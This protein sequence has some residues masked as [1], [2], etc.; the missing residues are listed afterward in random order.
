MKRPKPV[1]NGDADCEMTIN[2]ESAGTVN[3]YNCPPVIE[4]GSGPSPEPQGE[5]PPPPRAEGACIP[6]APGAKHKSG[7][8]R[9]LQPLIANSSAPSVLAATILQQSRRFLQARDPGNDLEAS[10][11][12]VLASLPPQLQDTLS[13]AVE[14]LDGLTKNERDS[15]FSSAI[16]SVDEALSTT[17]IA[18]NVVAELEEWA[19]DAA[20]GEDGCTTE[21]PGL[22]RPVFSV[23]NG[24]AFLGFLPSICRVNGLRTIY[25]NPS[26]GPGDYEPEEFEQ[27]CTP[28]VVD[29]E[30]EVN[31]EVQ[32]ED[33]PGHLLGGE[34]GGCLRVPDVRNGETVVLEGINFFNIDATVGLRAKAPGTATAEVDAFVCGDQETPATEEKNGVEVPIND[35]RVQDR[36]TFQVPDELPP[37]IYEARVVVPNDTG[38]ENTDPIFSSPEVFIRVVPPVTAEFQIATE[39]LRAEKETSPAWFGSDEVGIRILSVPILANN[40]LGS[41]NRLD[42][43]FGD[44]DS[45]E[46]R[47]MASVLI[48]ESGLSGVSI[49]IIGFE[50]DS[51]SAFE[52]QIDSFTDAF[53][54]ILKQVWDAIKEE[55]GGAVA[56]IVKKFG[57]K[58]IIAIV[59]AAIIAVA[60]IALVALWAP[61]D[62]IIEDHIGLSVLELATLTNANFPAP[63]EEEFTSTGGIDVKVVPVSKGVQYRERREYRSD[64]EDSDYRIT[65]RYNRLS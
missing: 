51:E 59:I 45:G 34:G 40:T 57:V 9:K 8:S 54:D 31:C 46:V 20:L 50:I 19:A 21:A 28:E 29:G 35:C 38:V 3:I 7:L 60:I 53:V 11:F 30:V 2:L 41:M 39:E 23:V 36:L 63:P 56:G 61:A 17:V 44:V 14:T 49:A 43:R 58:G 6:V 52:N 13:C 32:T 37:G 62:L 4:G 25:F 26:L 27:V 65:F 64:D 12:G 1:H 5:C 22:P 18:D 42:V 47:S 16:L 10:V 15:V 48:Q 33:C 24:G 55:V